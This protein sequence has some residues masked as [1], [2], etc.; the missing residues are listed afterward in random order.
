MKRTNKSLNST[1]AIKAD[2]CDNSED[3]SQNL[4]QSKA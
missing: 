3:N 2:D 4:R 1:K